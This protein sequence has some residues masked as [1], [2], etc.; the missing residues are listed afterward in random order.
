M[1]GI[2]ATSRNPARPGRGSLTASADARSAARQSTAVTC[3]GGG[4]L[5][6][7]L[8]APSWW[9]CRR[10]SPARPAR[11]PCSPRRPPPAGWT[12]L[13][14]APTS[15]QAPLID[16]RRTR[17]GPP[18]A[19]SS[20]PGPSGRPVG[21]LRE[22]VGQSLSCCSRESGRGLSGGES[23]GEWLRTSPVPLQAWP[24]DPCAEVGLNRSSL[25]LPVCPP[26]AVNGHMMPRGYDTPW[27]RNS[28]SAGMR[29]CS[30]RR[31]LDQT[32]RPP[33]DHRPAPPE[34]PELLEGQ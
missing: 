26:I 31:L 27:V 2:N 5:R 16:A 21:V 14:P 15:Q 11:L 3:C 20:P 32:A 34:V 28:R 22:R 19:R 17:S 33:G 9:I 18:D 24:P 13:T 10:G 4:A 7:G 23:E 1:T 29:D 30:L 6:H 25:T 12:R 8:S